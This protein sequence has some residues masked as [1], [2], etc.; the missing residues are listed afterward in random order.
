MKW[1]A[2][3]LAG[4]LYGSAALA[5]QTYDGEVEAPDWSP[6]PT[7]RVSATASPTRTP[8][9]TATPTP[10]VTPTPTATRTPKGA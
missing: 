4:L 6:T 5:V 3:F 7:P 9:W 2:L 8:N 1:I 10:V